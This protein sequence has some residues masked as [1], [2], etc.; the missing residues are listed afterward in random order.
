MKKFLQ[1]I[2]FFSL[3]SFLIRLLDDEGSSQNL[4]YVEETCAEYVQED[5]ITAD[6]FHQREWELANRSQSFCMG[7]TSYEA[8]SLEQAEERAAYSLQPL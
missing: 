1:V 7:Y 4:S 2:V 3:L 8:T 5:E 6:R